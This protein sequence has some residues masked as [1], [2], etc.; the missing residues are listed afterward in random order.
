[1]LAVSECFLKQKEKNFQS[2][3]LKYIIHRIPKVKF[4][5]FISKPTKK[6]REM[7][8]NVSNKK[9]FKKIKFHKVTSTKKKFK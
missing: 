5:K 8:V 1:M 3:P 2:L 9:N 7:L 4:T 6:T